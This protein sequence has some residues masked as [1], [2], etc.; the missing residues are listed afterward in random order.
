MRQ[1]HVFWMAPGLA[2]LAVAG[3]VS[4]PALAADEAAAKALARANNC[5]NCHA[6]DKKK[7]GPA[8]N[9]VAAKYKGKKDA[10]AIV[11]KH[12]TI[13]EKAK[14]DDGHEEDHPVIKSKNPDELKNLANWILSL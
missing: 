4:A 11:I 2:A 9:G 13:V 3:F 5:F 7:V 1:E 8:W 10:E 12:L 6:V 14:F